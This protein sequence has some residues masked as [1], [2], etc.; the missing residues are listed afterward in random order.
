VN[1]FLVVNQDRYVLRVVTG[2]VVLLLLVLWTVAVVALQR[3]LADARTP[4][5]LA[6]RSARALGAIVLA[7]GASYA[8]ATYGL[9]R[10]VS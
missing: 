7:L 3:W 5:T 6:V 9:T 10:Y 1:G 4:R 2:G 8:I